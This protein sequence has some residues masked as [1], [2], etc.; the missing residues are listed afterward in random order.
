MRQVVHCAEKD[1]LH[2]H[3][4]ENLCPTAALHTVS[5]WRQHARA[6][7]PPSLRPWDAAHCQRWTCKPRKRVPPHVREHLMGAQDG[8]ILPHIPHEESDMAAYIIGLRWSEPRGT[9]WLEPTFRTEALILVH[10]YR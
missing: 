5:P 2:C 4:L 10:F 8:H 1:P 6:A 9:A 3:C 7:V